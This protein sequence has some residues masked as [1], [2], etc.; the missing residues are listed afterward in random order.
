MRNYIYF[1]LTSLLLCLPISSLASR[2]AWLIL[3]ATGLRT[4]QLAIIVNDNDPLSV[5][6]ASYY[7]QSRDIQPHQIIHLRM[8]T[9]TPSISFRQFESIYAQTLHQTKPNTQA[10]V[11]TWAAPY[12][13]DCMSI[14]SAFTFGLDRDYCA[15]QS[16]RACGPT[17]LSPYVDANSTRPFDDYGIRPTMALAALDFDTAK[18][19]INRGIAA[20]AS[21]P[22]GTAYFL[23]TS[24]AARNRRLP[25]YKLAVS[26][27]SSRLPMTILHSDQLT[28]RD[29]VMFYFT[30]LAQ[31]EKIATNQFLPGAIADHLTSSG[32]RLTNSDQMSSLRWL[33]A[34]ATGSYGTVVEPCNY[35][36]KF[37]RPDILLRHYLAGD[38]LIEAYWKSVAW[39][40]EGIFIG[41]PLA[42]PYA[43][44]KLPILNN[45]VKLPNTGI[46]TGSYRLEYA[47]NPQGPY[48][49]STQVIVIKDSKPAPVLTGLVH[50]YY[51]L[52]PLNRFP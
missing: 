52:V 16:K 5:K 9:N 4:D 51:R 36:N 32:G 2:N 3:P 40:G 48:S 22:A 28:D 12:R 49:P 45:A 42:R 41:E 34:G 43:I 24:D 44:E 14:T 13:V 17:K 33:E 50:P 30:G 37:P 1:A 7:A 11:L 46:K 21:N 38:T 8:P 18:S 25:Y 26:R 19:L 35:P 6:I 27:F 39:P 29:D 15:K 23:S 10:Y 47:R 20:D 31:V